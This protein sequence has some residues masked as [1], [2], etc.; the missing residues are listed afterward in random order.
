M[1]KKDEIKKDGKADLFSIPENYFDKIGTPVKGTP[2]YKK[3]EE[4]GKWISGLIDMLVD[5]VFG[6]K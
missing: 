6:K 5:S 2:V 4:S 1:K 3:G